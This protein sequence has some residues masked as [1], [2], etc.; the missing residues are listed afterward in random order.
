MVIAV[1]FAAGAATTKLFSAQPVL[2]LTIATMSHFLLDIIP[3]H[4]L[5]PLQPWSYRQEKSTVWSFSW[6]IKAQTFALLNLAVIV[7]LGGWFLKSQSTV[8]FL[9]GLLGTLPDIYE[10]LAH[11]Y[12]YLPSVHLFHN[13]KSKSTKNAWGI[14]I[15]LLVFVASVILIYS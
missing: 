12:P 1:H 9:G 3:H 8:I 5:E 14:L 4:R 11:K 6:P 2:A 7:F 15:Q 10:W 13:E